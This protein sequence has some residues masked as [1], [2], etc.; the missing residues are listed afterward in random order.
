MQ[1]A[2]VEVDAILTAAEVMDVVGEVVALLDGLG[3][4]GVGLAGG[5]FTLLDVRDVVP[6][7]N[8]ELAAY[9]R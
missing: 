8:G 5:R 9:G 3:E 6:L 2:A 4:G 1:L 7:T